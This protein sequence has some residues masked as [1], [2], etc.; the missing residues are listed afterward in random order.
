LRQPLGDT[1]A[2]PLDGQGNVGPESLKYNPYPHD[3]YRFRL[4][5]PDPKRRLRGENNTFRSSAASD[6]A[7]FSGAW[8]ASVLGGGSIIWG[9]WSFRALPRVDG[10]EVARRLRK[11]KTAWRS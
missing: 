6:G 3:A 9:T 4:E 2:N 11:A 8:T 7:P 10:F 1:V 5:R